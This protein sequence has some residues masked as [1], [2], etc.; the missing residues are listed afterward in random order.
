MNQGSLRPFRL[1]IADD[2]FVV[3]SGI[4]ASLE[5]ERDFSIIAEAESSAQ[6]VELFRKHCP[7]AALLDVRLPSEGG[8]AVAAQICTEFPGARILMFSTFD[9]PEDIYRSI[10]AGAAGYLLKSA[11]REEVVGA[12]RTVLAGERY[13][14]GAAARRL[15]ER[16][17]GTSVTEREVQVIEL[18][19]RGTSNKKIGQILHISEDT[20][21]RHISNVFAKLR[22]RD[23]AQ[24]ATEALRRGLIRLE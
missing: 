12:L 5:E 17:A 24:A 6:A 21:K 14:H 7:D 13:L 8:I 18:I 2:H 11:P 22:V 23:R 15:A 16:V 19:A 10:Q 9:H 20:V 3:R 1:L 4:A